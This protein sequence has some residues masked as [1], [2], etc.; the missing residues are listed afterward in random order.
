[1]KYFLNYI[2]IKQISLYGLY[3]GLKFFFFNTCSYVDIKI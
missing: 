2:R 1:M 3:N